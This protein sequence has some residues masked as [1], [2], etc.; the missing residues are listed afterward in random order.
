MKLLGKKRIITLGVIAIVLFAG[1]VYAGSFFEFVKV[2]TGAMKNTIL[3][4]D[5][6][7]ANR[8][9]GQIKRGD[10]VLFKFP[11]DPATRFVSRVIGLPGD[12]L[13]SDSTTKTVLINDQ[14]LDEHR[15][16]V[17]PQYDSDDVTDLKTVRDEGGALWTVFYYKAEDDSLGAASFADD[18][19]GRNG[20][21]EPF[22]VSVKGDPIPDEI[23]G[24]GKLRRVYDSDNDGRYDDDQYYVLGDNR[25]NSLDSR[26]WGTVPRGLIDGKPFMIYWSVARDESAKETTRWNRVFAKLK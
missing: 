4:G 5:R 6:L 14:M 9:S 20:V 19:A 3:P 12:T 18:F 10:I 25:D 21:T 11:K 23:K 24:D 7:V 15:V 1:F 2:P 13:R 26:F 17:E 22:K 16:F 8:L